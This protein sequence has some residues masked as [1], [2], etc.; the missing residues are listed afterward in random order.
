MNRKFVKENKKVI[1]EFLGNLLVKIV[2][3]KL[4]KDLQKSIDNDP[5]IQKHTAQLQ[6]LEKQMLFKIQQK[7]DKDAVFAAKMKKAGFPKAKA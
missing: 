4:K 7:I 2:T 6:S 1:R 3:G 5:N